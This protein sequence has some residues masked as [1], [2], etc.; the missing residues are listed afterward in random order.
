MF[1]R[2]IDQSSSVASDLNVDHQVNHV[3]MIHDRG[4]ILFIL[5]LGCSTNSRPF[6]VKFHQEP[7][8]GS[9]SRLE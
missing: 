1:P 6:L 5:V 8:L 9:Q 4:K 2:V 3:R 7:R